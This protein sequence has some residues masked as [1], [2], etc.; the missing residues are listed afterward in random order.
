MA[1]ARLPDHA[2]AL[3]VLYRLDGGAD[4]P[5]R[6]LAA[7]R[8]SRVRARCGWGTAP[9]A[10]QLDIYGDLMQT[11]WLFA[12]AGHPIDREFGDRLAAIADLVCAHLAQ[13]DAGIWEVRGAC[14]TSP[15]RR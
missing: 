8:L 13:P 6:T 15:S 11:A 14:G 2:S 9:R 7:R 4:A 12:E 1:D 3:Q 10:A 5:E